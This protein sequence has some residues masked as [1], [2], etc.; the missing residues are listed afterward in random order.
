MH[1]D[2]KLIKKAKKYQREIDK[3]IIEGGPH[4]ESVIN[5]RKIRINDTMIEFRPLVDQIQEQQW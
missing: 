2:F 5:F 4:A 3:T 1:S